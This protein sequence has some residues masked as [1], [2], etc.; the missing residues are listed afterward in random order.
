MSYFSDYMSGKLTLLEAYARCESKFFKLIHSGI[1]D[2]KNYDA[3]VFDRD[4]LARQIARAS[5][6]A[7]GYMIDDFYGFREWRKI[8]SFNGFNI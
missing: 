5:L 1:Y 4:K 8:D 7:D 3:L 6:V 2:G